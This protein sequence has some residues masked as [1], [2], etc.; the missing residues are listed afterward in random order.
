MLYWRCYQVAVPGERD[1]CGDRNRWEMRCF[2]YRWSWAINYLLFCLMFSYWRH[3]AVYFPLLEW[4]CGDF[5][6]YC[7]GLPGHV[8][9]NIRLSIYGLSTVN[10]CLLEDLGCNLRARRYSMLHNNLSK[11]IWGPKTCITNTGFVGARRMLHPRPTDWL[12][13]FSKWDITSAHI[14]PL[15]MVYLSRAS[16]KS[17]ISQAAI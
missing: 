8:L 2:Y 10:D 1:K 15:T 11:S 12:I 17:F 14:P 3:N 7:D 16:E 5:A 13:T 6:I 9:T 4:I